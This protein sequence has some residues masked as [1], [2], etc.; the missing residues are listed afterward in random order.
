MSVNS[1]C[2]SGEVSAPVF[3]TETQR[4][5]RD[6]ESKRDLEDDPE[7][8]QKRF[9]AWTFDRNQLIVGPQR[10]AYQVLRHTLGERFMVTFTVRVFIEDLLL[11]RIVLLV[12]LRTAHFRCEVFACA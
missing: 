6:T 3:T 1:L 7:A 2:L 9:F 10:W 5:H 4:T 12:C 8:K 11:T